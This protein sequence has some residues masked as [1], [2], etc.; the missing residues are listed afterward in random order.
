M[1]KTVTRLADGRELI[2]F[3]AADDLDRSA[4]DLRDLAADPIG[5]E[6]RRDPFTDEWVGVATRRNTRTF[7]PSSDDC[8]LCPSRPGH[9]TE[10]PA[11]EYDVAVFENRFPSFSHRPPAG[12]NAIAAAGRCEVVC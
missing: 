2:Y 10:I 1:K 5:P 6:M 9:R 8:P 4:P 11:P 7:L 12:E 3:D